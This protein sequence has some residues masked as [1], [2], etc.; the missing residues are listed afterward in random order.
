MG[1]LR[2]CRVGEEEHSHLGADACHFCRLPKKDDRAK[3]EGKRDERGEEVEGESCLRGVGKEKDKVA[4]MGSL[5]DGDGNF[6]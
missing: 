6:Q 4:E 1:N 2:R 5:P 3:R